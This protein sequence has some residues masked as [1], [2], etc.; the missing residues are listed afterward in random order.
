MGAAPVLD[1]RTA[2]RSRR[3]LRRIPVHNPAWTDFNQSDPGITLVQLFAFL[4]ESLLWLT[5]ERER[6]RRR[7]RAG[8]LA[9]LVAG[10]AGVGL[11][12]RRRSKDSCAPMPD[13]NRT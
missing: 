8:R 3:R 12:V 13:G 5:D 2:R 6:Q 7:R 10:A 1:E 9:F 11:A 4:V